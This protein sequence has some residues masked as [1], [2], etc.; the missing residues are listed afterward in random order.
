MP[1]PDPVS[2]PPP[3]SLTVTVEGNDN[4]YCFND[5][6][7]EKVTLSIKGHRNRVICGSGTTLGGLSIQ[8]VG[9]DHQVIIGE[10]CVI[11]GRMVVKGT[12]QRI[13]IGNRTSF[14]NCYLLAQM[15]GGIEIGRA[16]MFSRQIEIRA[17]D[18]H[19]VI[20]IATGKRVNLDGPVKIGNHV[21][22]AAGV[23]VSKGVTIADDVIVGAGSA[24]L[25]DITESH[26]VAAGRPAVV[27]KR[28]VTWNRRIQATFTEEEM[29][30]WRSW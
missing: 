17:T 20:E 22:L 8:I 11:R 7:L 18:A 30:E 23:L 16:C 29:N 4:E 14:V 15:G 19:S 10:R 1:P 26:T 13:E 27:V 6:K 5:A 9:N 2:P 12:A 3:S 28:G 24:V 21:W 25:K